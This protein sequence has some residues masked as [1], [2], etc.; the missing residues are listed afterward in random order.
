MTVKEII[1]EYLKKNEY[2]GLCN[3]TNQRIPCECRIENLMNCDKD[4]TNCS[5]C[6]KRHRKWD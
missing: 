2:Y 5:P 1:L 4:I 6:H 3:D